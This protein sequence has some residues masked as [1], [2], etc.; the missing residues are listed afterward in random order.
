MAR[1]SIRDLGM[2]I[3]SIGLALTVYRYLWIPTP[4]PHSR[5]HL[6]AYLAILTMTMLGSFLAGPRPRLVC[7]GYSL[8][9]WL[10]LIFVMHCGFWM[11][12]FNDAE[13]VVHGSYLGISLGILCGVLAGWLFAASA[14][15]VG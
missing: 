8:F 10:N 12:E 13:R 15:E 6:A 3:L 9:A 11:R 5:P 14:K 1:F 2:L 4:I 7:Q